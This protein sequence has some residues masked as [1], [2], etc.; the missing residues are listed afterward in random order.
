VCFKELCS[1]TNGHLVLETGGRNM[2]TKEFYEQI[3][4]NKKQFIFFNSAMLLMFGG[5]FFPLVIPLTQ[6]FSLHFFILYI[7]MSLLVSSIYIGLYQQW[8]KVFIT[9]LLIHSAGLLWRVALEWGEDGISNLLTF[10]IVTSY[11]LSVP[12]FITVLYVIIKKV[13][14]NKRQLDTKGS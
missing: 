9:V 14:L 8:M 6:V 3:K 7:I 10:P 1:S 2:I 11:I 13:K 5:G 12:I 4:N